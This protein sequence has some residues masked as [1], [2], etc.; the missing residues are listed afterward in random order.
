MKIYFEESFGP[1]L[2]IIKA[3]TTSHA[4]EIANSSQYGLSSSI[5]SKVSSNPP[6]SFFPLRRLIPSSFPRSLAGHHDRS[7]RRSIPRMFRR[8]HQLHHRSRRVLSPSRRTQELRARQVQRILR[9]SVFHA[10]EDGHFQ[11]GRGDGSFAF[12]CLSKSSW[13]FGLVLS[14][15]S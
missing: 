13:G 14:T 15:S 11:D 10:D 9:Y 1:A 8:P 12:A 2:S 3:K 6:P 5:W 7:L 4:V